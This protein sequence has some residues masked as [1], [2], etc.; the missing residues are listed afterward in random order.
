MLGM[1]HRYE[2]PAATPVPSRVPL[3]TRLL[4]P[5]VT[6]T[7]PIEGMLLGLFHPVVPAEQQQAELVLMSRRLNELLYRRKG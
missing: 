5:L 6:T 3:Q 1:C 4:C 2:L 7:G